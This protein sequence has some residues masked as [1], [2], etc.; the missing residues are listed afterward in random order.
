MYKCIAK[1]LI[2]SGF[3]QVEWVEQQI[4]KRRVKRGALFPDPLWKDQWYLV[5]N[6]AGFFEE[7]L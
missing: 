3:L 4:V 7:Q 5:G 6:I 2:S 1:I